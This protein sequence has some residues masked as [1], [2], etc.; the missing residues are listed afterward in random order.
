[1]TTAPDARPVRVLHLEDSRVDH[2]LVKFALRRNGVDFQLQRVETLGDLLRELGTGRYDAVLADYELEGFTALDARERA[3]GL[4]PRVPWVVLSGAIGEAAA[5]QTVRHG[6]HD[7]VLKD[8]LE[9]LEFVLLRAIEAARAEG[10]RIDAEAGRRRAQDQ[11]TELSAHMQETLEDERAEIAREVHDDIGGALAAVKLDIAWVR[12]Q[13]L[14][15]DSA[16]H[17]DSALEMLE[18]AIGASR[19]IMK[20]LRPA[21][22]DQGLSAAVAWLLENFRRRS[23]AQVSLQADSALCDLPPEVVLT[24]FRTVQEAL[25]N[26]SKHAHARQVKVSLSD[27]G[28]M[29]MVE[30][31]DD[32][33]G[34]QQGAQHK[35]ESF[36]LR[37]LRERA[38]RV[39]GWLDVT[40]RPGATS[41]ILTVPLRVVDRAEDDDGLQPPEENPS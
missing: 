24:A 18:H 12:R 8:N 41:V 20:S 23:G 27:A 28:G 3:A 6:M 37:G 29:L 15:A 35:P 17:L 19:R 7:Y 5:V 34:L 25:T 13:P 31:D 38:R 32:G 33:V 22:L 36:G 2:E 26:A 39:G 14:S 9:R 40:S 10:E 16:R 11:L 4:A 21:V 30:I 1:M